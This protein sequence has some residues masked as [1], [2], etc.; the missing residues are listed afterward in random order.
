MEDTESKDSTSRKER[1]SR[2]TIDKPWKSKKNKIKKDEPS[3]ISIYSNKE[4][5]KDN[6]E[7]KIS[8]ATRKRLE[9]QTIAKQAQKPSRPNLS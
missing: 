4:I 1:T 5:Q 9:A 3:S 2:P 7:K 6:P 8:S